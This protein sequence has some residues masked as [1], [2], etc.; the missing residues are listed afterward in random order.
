MKVFISIILMCGSLFGQ[1]ILEKIIQPD[2]VLKGV[3]FSK[4]AVSKFGDIY[5]IDSKFHEIYNV[6]ND[7]LILRK[8]GGFGWNE[9]QFDTPTDICV[10]SGLELL[11][12]DLNNHRITLYD[13]NLN[14]VTVFP[15]NGDDRIIPFPLSV[16]VSEIGEMFVLENENRDVLKFNI[17]NNQ[18]TTFAGFEYGKYSLMEPVQ[19]R[20]S[21]SGN[22]YVLEKSG[23]VLIFDRF[24]TFLTEVK[25]PENGIAIGMTLINENILIFFDDKPGAILYSKQIDEWYEPAQVGGNSNKKWIAGALNDSKIYLLTQTGSI[26]VC[27]IN[28]LK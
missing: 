7:G 24:G 22:L 28:E 8:N 13:R 1:L 15:K 5:L 20:I 25:S 21:S 16:A 4:I 10:S 6:N 12:A 19:I 9:G 23:K 11:V 26:L 17:L 3:R 27:D 18:V 14:Y 2:P